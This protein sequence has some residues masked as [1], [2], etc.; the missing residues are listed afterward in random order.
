MR[1]TVLGA[2]GGAGRAV[3]REL[4]E[5]GHAV[6]AA[7]R[8]VESQRVGPGVRP[9]VTD[10]WD[11][12]QA[13]QACADAEVVVMAAL[14]PYSRWRDELLPLYDR[15]VDA[16]AAAGA[17]L[18]VV[19]NLYAYGSPGVPISE[20]TPEAAT[21]RKG[22]LRAELGRRLLAAHEQGRLRVTIGRFADY[23]GPYGT[24]SLVYQI[25]IKPGVGGKNV[26]GFID[27]DQPHTFVYLPDAARGF[28]SLVEDS[29]ADGRVWILPAAPPVTQRELLGLLAEPLGRRPKIGR[30]TPA[31][32]ALAGVFDRE[33][34]EAREVV[35]QFDRPYVTDA[36]AF[37]AAFGTVVLTPHREAMIETVAWARGEI[38]DGRT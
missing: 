2:M 30:V 31:M 12:D 13:R 32:L 6:T 18:V 29:S 1:V 34:R 27:L 36:S 20:T 9:V 25:G 22:R 28:A 10:L 37:E 4:V 16:A 7:S 3:V 35:P 21:T 38:E 19:D 15:A 23:Y 24:N 14:I 26:R 5:R 8:S 11:A 33:L 17:R